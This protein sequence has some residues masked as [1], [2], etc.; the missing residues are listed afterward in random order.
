MERIMKRIKEMLE[1]SG[2][3]EVQEGVVPPIMEVRLIEHSVYFSDSGRGTAAR[4]VFT[5][6]DFEEAYRV[7]S[8]S[9]L[10]GNAVV[11]R[12]VEDV[13]MMY[14]KNFCKDFI[15]AYDD[16]RRQ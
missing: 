11:E 16:E 15:E 2:T 5:G 12:N 4:V 6:K 9:V 3:L 10:E 13:Y 7:L 8:E 14:L 1:K